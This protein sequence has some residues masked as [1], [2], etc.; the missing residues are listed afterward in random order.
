MSGL[1]PEPLIL[2]PKPC[3][4]TRLNIGA[5]ANYRNCF[6]VPYDNYSIL[7]PTPYSN[8]WGYITC[9]LKH[10]TFRKSYEASNTT[11]GGVFYYDVGRGR[12]ISSV[13][14]TASYGVSV[15]I[16][17]WGSRVVIGRV[18]NPLIW[19]ISIV[20]LCTCSPTYHD[21]GTSNWVYCWCGTLS[22][23]MV[24]LKAQCPLVKV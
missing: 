7:D 17:L 15:K 6:G 12:S 16:I 2:Y 13:L 4:I 11:A 8:Y 14:F 10:G 18:K 9:R 24:I 23:R 20:T 19:V 21:P 5:L 3:K 22:F 1:S